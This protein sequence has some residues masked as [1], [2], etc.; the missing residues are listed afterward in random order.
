VVALG[1]LAGAGHAALAVAGSAVVTLILATRNQSHRFVAH[2][3][4][5]DVRAFARY[6]V[7]GAAV[8]LFLP[9]R[10]VGPLGAWNPFQLWLV[11][12]LITGFPFA[13]YIAYRAIGARKG[14]LATALIGGAYSSTAVTASFAERLAAGEVGPLSAG[15]M[16][17]SAVMYVRVIVLVG[18]LSP[19][20]L[21]P[22]FRI[23]A[24]ATVVGM[25][26]AA[27]AWFRAQHGSASKDQRLR[28]PAELV[29]VHSGEP[30]GLPMSLP[31]SEWA[32]Q[33]LLQ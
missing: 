9:N 30:F 7:I 3:N 23:T 13:G 1:L 20:T 28:N 12:V 11:V 24:P 5:T 16:I 27:F 22:L 29:P 8:L 17:A 21:V 6:A 19:S 33:A 2:L 10:A 4:A 15:I 32:A 18:V 25:A 26:T 31:V 14:V